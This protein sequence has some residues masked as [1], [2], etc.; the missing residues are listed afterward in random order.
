MGIQCIAPSACGIIECPV[1]VGMDIP[2]R[3][4]RPP[5]LHKGKPPRKI[6]PARPSRPIVDLEPPGPGPWW[7]FMLVNVAVDEDSKK[8]T[9]V[10]L[11]TSP[12][13]VKYI[14]NVTDPGDWAIVMKLGPFYDL[15][16]AGQVLAEW[17][18]GTR[19]QGPR[20]AQGICLW[21]KYRDQGIDLWA[22]D[23]PKHEVQRAFCEKRARPAFAPRSET[24]SQD[25]LTVR[26]I[27]APEGDKRKRIKLGVMV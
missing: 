11:D 2:I 24:T 13:L 17:S 10:R 21:H 8:Q 5:P 9:E 1:G 16:L 15:N 3:Q 23:Q 22:I 4:R 12:E 20:I 25:Y 6:P 7:P 27:L 19:G 14:K 26:E 18:D